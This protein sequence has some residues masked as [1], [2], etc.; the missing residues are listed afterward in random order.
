LF[1]DARESH[2]A[3]TFAG[4]KTSEWDIPLVVQLLE[5]MVSGPYIRSIH[6]LRKLH[7]DIRHGGLLT[8]VAFEQHFVN[9]NRQIINGPSIKR[10]CVRS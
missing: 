3:T 8:A 1:A 6:K 10:C 7:N 9:G 4:G 2:F 5:L